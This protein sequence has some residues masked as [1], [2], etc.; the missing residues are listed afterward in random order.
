[1][2]GIYMYD[3]TAT[4]TTFNDTRYSIEHLSAKTELSPFILAFV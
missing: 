1:M 3:Y 2:F 4:T